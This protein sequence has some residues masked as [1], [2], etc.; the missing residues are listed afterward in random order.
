MDVRLDAYLLIIML[1]CCGSAISHLLSRNEQLFFAYRSDFSFLKVHSLNFKNLVAYSILGRDLRSQ[2]NIQ[3]SFCPAMQCDLSSPD[4]R[5]SHSL[6]SKSGKRQHDHDA[7]L[8]RHYAGRVRCVCHVCCRIC[9]WMHERMG[10]VCPTCPYRTYL[11]ACNGEL[12]G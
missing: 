10:D 12:S 6:A 4:P 5:D 8:L 1:A 3:R 7:Y 2:K 9:T 11:C